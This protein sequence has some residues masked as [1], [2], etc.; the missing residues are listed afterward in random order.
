MDICT[1]IRNVTPKGGNVF[2]DL[3]FAHGDAVKLKIKAQLM[4]KLTTWIKNNGLNQN[5]AAA[6]FGIQRT[7]VSDLMRGKIQRFTI[8][9][10]V[11][12]LEKSGQSYTITT[13]YEERT[14]RVTVV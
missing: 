7:R 13:S 10:L 5:D 11:D 2:D 9:A 3:G 8:D 12:M 14:T 6:I 4:V 1:E